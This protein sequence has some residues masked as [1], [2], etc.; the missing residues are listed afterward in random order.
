MQSSLVTR[1]DALG[2][3]QLFG[4]LHSTGCVR[5]DTGAGCEM[6]GDNRTRPGSRAVLTPATAASSGLANPPTR[7]RPSTA[8]TALV[9]EPRTGLCEGYHHPPQK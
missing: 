6:G 1:R 4:I 9:S 7:D 8:L 2:S 3:V 5:R